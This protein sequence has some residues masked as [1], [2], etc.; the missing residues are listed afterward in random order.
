MID[1]DDEDCEMHKKRVIKANIRMTLK[2]GINLHWRYTDVMRAHRICGIIGDRMLAVSRDDPSVDPVITST[3]MR[4]EFV[5]VDKPMCSKAKNG[6]QMSNAAMGK[7]EC[8]TS[9]VMV[10][11][12]AAVAVVCPG[13]NVV[14][15]TLP[16]HYITDDEDCMD[17]LIWGRD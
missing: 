5:E 12:I 13:C 11:D 6:E 14:I 15:D 17:P 8:A 3:I 9:T 10:R 16:G 2:T 4:D 7:K 1:H